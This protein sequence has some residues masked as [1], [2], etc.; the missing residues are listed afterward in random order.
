MALPLRT[1][2][3]VIARREMER[4]LRGTRRHV[5]GRVRLSELAEVIAAARTASQSSRRSEKRSRM[6]QLRDELPP[7][8]RA[9]LVLRVDRGLPWEEIALAFVENPEALSEEER[10]REASRL[11]KRFQLVKERLARRIKEE[12]L[13][14]K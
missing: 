13:L 4:F 1:W 14:S 5:A 9:L 3:Y 10:R 8:D 2:T 6:E 7:E 11:R 12:G